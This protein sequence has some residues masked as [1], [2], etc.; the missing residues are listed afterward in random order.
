[1]NRFLYHLLPFLIIT[2]FFTQEAKGQNTHAD[3]LRIAQK[4]TLDSMKAAQKQRTDS[5]KAIRVYR[6]SKRYKD[7]LQNYRQQRADSLKLMRQKTSDSLIAIRKKTSDSL[8]QI[9]RDYNDSVRNAL[10]NARAE[11]K[12]DLE[13][14]MAERKKIT[15]SLAA[16][17]D[18]K[19]SKSYKDSIQLVRKQHSDS[20]RDIRKHTSDSL[21]AIQTAKTDS[22]RTAIKN[23]NDSLRA[24]LDSTKAARQIGLDSIA[25][26][27]KIRSD[28]LAQVRTEKEEARK[29]KEEEKEKKRKLK[30]EMEISKKQ[31]K[32]TNET[33]RKK[34]WTMPR[35]IVQNTFTRYN[36]YFNANKKMELAHENMLRSH[37]DNYDSLI[38]IFPFDPNKDST[39]LA[40]DMDSI[41]KTAAVG[42]QIHDPR[43]KWQDNLYLLVGEAYYYKGDYENAGAAF[44]QIIVLAEEEKKAKDKAKNKKPEKDAVISYSE[45]EKTGIAGLVEHI[46][47]K[48]EAMLWLARTL[49]K[50]NKEGQA[51]TILDLLKNDP[52]FPKSLEGRLALEQANMDLSREDFKNEIIH[53][54]IVSQD[55]NSPKWLRLRSSF[56]TAQLLQNTGDLEKSNQ[57]FNQAVALHPNLEMNF[58][59]KKN[60][61]FNNLKMN[62]NPSESKDIIKNMIAESKYTPY[63]DQLYFALAKANT[64]ENNHEEAIENLKL[65][66]SHAQNNKKQ[67]GYSFATLGDEY[68]QQRLYTNAK[69]AYDSAAMFL[70][71]DQDP[72]F[73][74]SK[75]RSESLNEIVAP[76]EI[77]RN[78]DSLLHLSSLSEKE[79]KSVI[80]NYIKDYEKQLSDS[81]FLAE[82]SPGVVPGGNFNQNAQ[83][84]YFSNPTL[85]QKGENDFKQKWGERK[86][87]DNWRRS[88]GFSGMD[89]ADG[90]S[91]EQDE[92]SL[93]PDEDSLY[94][95][96]PHSREEI[97]TANKELEAGLF[98]LG[99]GYY[100]YLEDF[101]NAL[102]T[103][104]TLDLRFQNHKFKPEVLY[105]RYLIAMRRNNTAS[106]TQYNNQLQNNYPGSEWA[107]LLQNAD[108]NAPTNSTNLEI[109]NHYD[110]T[111]ALLKERDFTEVLKRIDFADKEFKNKGDFD[112][113]YQLLK[114]IAIAGNG[115]YPL[116]DT[117]LSQFV[118]T[119]PKDSLTTWANQVLTFIRNGGQTGL[120]N[121]PEATAPEIPKLLQM[122]YTYNAS[123]KHF[124]ILTAPAD[125]RL[126][127]LKSGLM[128]FNMMKSEKEQI[129]LTM[130]NFTQEDNLLLFKEFENAEAAKKYIN[131]IKNNKLLFRE[132]PKKDYT[133]T[134]ISADNYPIFL[135]KKNLKDYQS[136]YSKNYK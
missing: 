91:Q 133:L 23:H 26:V 12:K 116:A 47:S 41:L 105:M 124:V 54:S 55:K 27:R 121:E 70:T 67:K 87:K 109:S 136:F 61:V 93:L 21:R 98:L 122:P 16:I 107:K 57:F 92:A 81:K 63:Y 49:V 108:S 7:S 14:K 90:N 104:D 75:Q 99:K 37:I 59:A 30:F 134:I 44:K 132:Y 123:S 31:D 11:L 84:W 71:K 103:F 32:F 28:S 18:Y 13:L 127:A 85:V 112:K 34:G 76:A 125:M 46:S 115:D 86:L 53:L 78:Q 29:L 42:I 94:A 17:R 126:F 83:T 119:Y 72:I 66:I 10:E 131:G 100:T 52:N 95:A 97:A 102:A 19:A 20:L 51:Q 5:L 25:A 135:A 43:A 88:S 60:V 58:Y 68:Y 15:D 64:L 40:S 80:R 45:K 120:S 111:Y 6:E 3:S 89:M 113:K 77:V 101:D 69:N 106:A 56:L 79:Q 96:I 62:A 118:T 48:N 65:S 74:L 50:S 35:K 129:I 110:E 4:A 22:M 24:S 73:S 8:L 130:T 117:L 128:D 36:Y 82:N 38:P 39:K 33:M 1:M 9:R 114:A 2:L